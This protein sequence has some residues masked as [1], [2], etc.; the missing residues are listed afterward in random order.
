M[1]KIAFDIKY[2]PEIEA[3]KYKVVT[4][5]GEPVEIVK[6]DCRGKYPILAVIDD[7]DTDDCT[8][9]HEDGVGCTEEELL[10]I[11]TDEP[12]ELTEYENRV[13]EILDYAMANPETEMSKIVEQG[14][15]VSKELF[16]LAKK[17]LLSYHDESNPKI[18]A[19][20]DLESAVSCGGN[21][22]IWLADAFHKK[23]FEGYVKGQEDAE[24]RH[25][26]ATSFHYGPFPSWPPPC[27][28][29][30]PCTNPHHDC[31]NCHR[32][33]TSGIAKTDTNIK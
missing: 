17:E 32:P 22:P 10:V 28:V 20:A 5:H 15:A 16:E 31:I 25:R 29:G 9:F 4:G 30:G 23:Y 19:I 26:E 2:R 13:I 18:E 6:W 12:D 8:F 27:F 33:G 1:R 24:K 7:G 21:L 11:I 14:K 3:G